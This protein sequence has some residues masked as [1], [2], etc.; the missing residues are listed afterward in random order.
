MQYLPIGGVE[1][2]VWDLEE[3]F[4]GLVYAGCTGIDDY[5]KPKNIYTET[6]AE[7]S[8]LKV[9]TPSSLTRE[10]TDI[11]LSLY[12]VGANRSSV[13]H[14]F[15]DYISG[16]KLYLWDD[17]RNRKVAIIQIEETSISEEEFVG[18]VPNKL[19][20]FKFKNI[21]GQSFAV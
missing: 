6:F 12:F 13:Y 11:V 17:V 16:H 19:I 1:Q 2:P 15:M 18:S 8:E 4:D 10:N 7:T 21:H 3:H 5:G 20:A 14:S 9:H